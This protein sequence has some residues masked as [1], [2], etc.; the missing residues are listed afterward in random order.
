MADE[1]EILDLCR[2]VFGAEMSPEL[3][4]WRFPENPFAK[5]VVQVA[6]DRAGKIIGHYS[7]VPVPLWKDGKSQLGSYSILT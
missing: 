6:E 2:R 3:W 5:A 1:D 4:R 7:Q